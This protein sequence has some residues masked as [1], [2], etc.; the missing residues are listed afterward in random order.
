MTKPS[1][2]SVSELPVCP[3]YA[4]DLGKSVVRNLYRTFRMS[5]TIGFTNAE[6]LCRIGSAEVV[7]ETARLLLEERIVDPHQ[8]GDFHLPG[9]FLQ[10]TAGT[11]NGFSINTSQ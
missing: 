10:P 7:H 4:I 5:S 3:L 11:P 2:E 9:R 6:P 1:L 8:I